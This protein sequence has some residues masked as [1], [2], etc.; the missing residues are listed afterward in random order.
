MRTFEPPPPYVPY[1]ERK[2]K[3]SRFRDIACRA[4]ALPTRLGADGRWYHDDESVACLDP[5]TLTPYPLDS[6]A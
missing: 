2:G 3:P 5:E 4:C 6:T 1:A